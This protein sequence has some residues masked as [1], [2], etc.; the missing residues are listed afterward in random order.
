M[1]SDEPTSS[2]TTGCPRCTCPNSAAWFL[3]ALHGNVS[4]AA[5][6]VVPA[7]DGGVHQVSRPQRG[8]RANHTVQTTS[9]AGVRSEACSWR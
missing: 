2:I 4:A 3:L 7:V 6:V 1:A 8:V 9:K 5:A